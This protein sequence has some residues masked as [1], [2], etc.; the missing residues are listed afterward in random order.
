MRKPKLTLKQ[1]AIMCV[2]EAKVRILIQM[3]S[4]FDNRILEE[5]ESIGGLFEAVTKDRKLAARKVIWFAY[6][7]YTKTISIKIEK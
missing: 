5:Y 1:F 7:D 6:N 2:M 3:N 4:L